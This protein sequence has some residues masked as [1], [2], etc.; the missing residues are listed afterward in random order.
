MNGLVKQFVHNGKDFG[1][2]KPFKIRNKARWEN[3]VSTTYGEI[4][5]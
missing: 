4:G 3:G 2:C 5:K 1:V